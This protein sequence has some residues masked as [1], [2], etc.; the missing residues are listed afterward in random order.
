MIR[1]NGISL[2]AQ[3]LQQ[4]L[5]GI[6]LETTVGPR[7]Y[8]SVADMLRPSPPP[9][10]GSKYKPKFTLYAGPLLQQFSGQQQVVI[11]PWGEPGRSMWPD[12]VK[13]IEIGGVVVGGLAAVGA[14]AILK[15][16]LGKG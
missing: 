10:F 12:I 16:L 1:Y 13:D 2:D 15:A 6:A 9:S 11:A 8:I 5:S 3:T 14:V 7:V 4:L